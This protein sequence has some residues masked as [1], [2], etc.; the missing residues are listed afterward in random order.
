[1]SACPNV[2]NGSAVSAQLAWAFSSEQVDVAASDLS[3]L[4]ARVEEVIDEVFNHDSLSNL[5]E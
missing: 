2:N 3:P 4:G 1:M 5:M